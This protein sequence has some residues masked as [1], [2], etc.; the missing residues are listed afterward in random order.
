MTARAAPDTAQTS[1]AYRRGWWV[2]ST[3]ADAARAAAQRTPER[4]ALVDNEV[5]LNCATLYAQAGELAAALLARIPAGSVVSFML[6]NWH[7]AAVI[8]LAATL[9]GM[10]VNPI[11]P[12]LRD[13]DLRF[14]LEDAG[15]AM[16]FVPYRY[17]GHDY[18][19]MLDRVTAAMSAAPQ[20]VVL[21]GPDTGRTGRHTPY[22]CM[23]GG[24]PGVL[25]ALDPDAV[26]MI[27]YTSGTTSRP[28]GVL[29]THNS[30]HALI[31]QIRDHWAIDPGDTFLVP[32]PLAHIGGSIYAFECPLLLGTTAVLMDRWDPARAVALMTAHRCTHMAGAT[33]FLQQLLS[34]AA[35]AGT[36]L[37]DLKVFICGGASVS[38]SLI[39][40]AAA[41]FDRAVVTR[42]Y[43]CTEVPVATVGAPR[44]QEAA[45]AADTDGRPGIAEIKLVAHP[46]APTG[47]GEICVRGPQMLRG[48]RHPED[49]TES[50]DAAGF[51]R[52]GDLGRWAL[53][54]S[55]G[56]YLVVT[57]RAKDVIIRSGENI[58]AKEVEDLLADHPGIA[59]IAVVGL[60][61]ERT[62]ERACA[63]IVPTP[64]ASPDVASL[65]ALLVS[66]GVA[67]FKAPEQVVLW[68][69]LPKNDAG[70]VLKHR[71][72][73][74]LSK[75]G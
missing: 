13:H 20:V 23:L 61:D 8:Y 40:R 75:D 22:R 67:K 19:A 29:H 28:K 26:R 45:Y 57:G 53:A 7:E 46:A 39:R 5:R 21:R 44:P 30:I 52:T 59:E 9:A 55:A 25:P 60:P 18:P 62:G 70:K 17:G 15:A 2:R 48:Y 10:V 11:L 36:R 37:P 66:K 72:R 64:G 12:S 43:G 16:V 27:L 4:I 56:R 32:S 3:L 42:V 14:I 71:I 35:N 58:S 49:D 63:V 31:C 41:Y 33:P 34:A 73:A 24:P 65:L 54:D 74:A 38:P 51:F 68:D 1:L 6:P 50:F 47:D 69:A